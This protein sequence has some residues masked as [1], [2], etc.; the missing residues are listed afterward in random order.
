MIIDVPSSKTYAS[1]TIP[2]SGSASEGEAKCAGRGRYA[3]DAALSDEADDDAT[4]AGFTI[5]AW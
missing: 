3:C 1:K 2:D 4:D 5:L